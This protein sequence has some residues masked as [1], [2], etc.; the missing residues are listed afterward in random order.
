MENES[1]TAWLAA[2]SG[3]YPP[4]TEQITI[5][6]DT[7]PSLSQKDGALY[8]FIRLDATQSLLVSMPLFVT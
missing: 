3:K 1:N 8:P 6:W 2:S 5:H 4:V 7:H